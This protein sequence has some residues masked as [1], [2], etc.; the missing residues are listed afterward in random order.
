M[1]K[2]KST[3]TILVLVLAGIVLYWLMGKKYL[4][5]IA[6]V[7]GVIGVFVPFLA[8]QIHWAWHKMGH[9]MGLITG[10]IL[11]G[12]V[13]FVIL[14][15]LSAA[16]KLFRKNAFQVKPGSPSYFKDRNMEYTKETM[17]NIW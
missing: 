5:T 12:I 6:F 3:E 4:L 2:K 10:K 13:F 7:L 9:Y 16:S 1:D 8:N 14:Y 15:P 17:E 11:L